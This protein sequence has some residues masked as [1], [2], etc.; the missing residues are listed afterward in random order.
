VSGAM[1]PAPI[2]DPTLGVQAKPAVN[3][4]RVANKIL[5]NECLFSDEL[6]AFFFL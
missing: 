5:M 2:L 6:I 1:G 3:S 4:N